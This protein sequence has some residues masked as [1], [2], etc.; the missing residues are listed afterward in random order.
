MCVLIYDDATIEFVQDMA[1]SMALSAIVA[2]PSDSCNVTQ[3]ANNIDS[4]MQ[5]ELES[6]ALG[7]RDVAPASTHDSGLVVGPL[8]L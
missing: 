3:C 4:A 7:S 5:I 6:P 8:S 1:A 2:K